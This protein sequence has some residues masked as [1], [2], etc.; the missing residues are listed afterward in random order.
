MNVSVQL[1]SPELIHAYLYTMQS[2]LLSQTE[3][4][5]SAGTNIITINTQ[6]LA[7]G[8]YTIELIYGNRTCFAK[9]QKL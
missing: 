6:N 2:V 4:Q 7:A 3:Q 8:T 1:T 9:F 5:G